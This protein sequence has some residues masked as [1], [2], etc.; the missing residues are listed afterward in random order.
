MAQAFSMIL[1]GM[2]PV[3]GYG[4]I[5]NQLC[6]GGRQSVGRSARDVTR[7]LP[8][9]LANRGK[10]G[11]CRRRGRALYSRDYDHARARGAEILL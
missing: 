8:P 4:R 3:H 11:W 2:A 6:F 5:G 10:T 1:A 9:V 7:P